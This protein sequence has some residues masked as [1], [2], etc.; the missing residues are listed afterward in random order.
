MTRRRLAHAM[1]AIRFVL[2]IL[3]AVALLAGP[4][5]AQQRRTV[6][7]WFLGFNTTQP[8][9]DNVQARRAVA[10]AIDRARIAA[11]DDNLV[12]TG[13]EPPGCL[14][15]NPS[16]RAHTY[17]TDQ[18]KALLAQSG[19]KFDEVGDLGLWFLSL[20]RQIDVLRRELE[21][22][23]GNLSAAGLQ[24]T[25]REFGNYTAFDRIATLPVVKMSYWGIGWDT[26]SCAQGTFLEALG[27]SRG[28]FN[29]FGYRN[30]E[31]DALIDRARTAGD[32][33]TRI[34]LFQEAEQKI[35]DDAIL[36]PVWWWIQR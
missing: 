10:A 2:A 23:T 21:I 12:A 14:A 9:F 5:A 29:R 19:V 13:V 15:H 33:G 28:D 24:V 11:V 4:V 26:V 36:V 20:L 25:L 31:V 22:L 16:A 27:H 17:N 3:L 1:T 35:L 7:I 6:I 18:A 30:A 8:P 34:R 32:R